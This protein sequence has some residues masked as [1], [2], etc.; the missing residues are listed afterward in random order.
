MIIAYAVKQ[1]S[2]SEFITLIRASL[3]EFDSIKVKNIN[4][5][6]SIDCLEDHVQQMPHSPTLTHFLRFLNFYRSMNIL[7]SKEALLAVKKTYLM[8]ETHLLS[9]LWSV[10]MSIR[11]F[12]I[13]YVTVQ[14]KFNIIAHFIR[15]S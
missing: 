14:Y 2:L 6:P 13:N 5:I 4:S 7:I 8:R 11:S 9:C 3:V 15:I 12:S 1:I 10:T